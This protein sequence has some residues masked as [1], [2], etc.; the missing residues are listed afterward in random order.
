MTMCARILSYGYGTTSV[1]MKCE[2]WKAAFKVMIGNK[3]DKGLI[4]QP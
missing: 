3:H 1:G 4:S 2:V